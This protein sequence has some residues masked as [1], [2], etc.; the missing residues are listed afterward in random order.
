MPIYTAAQDEIKRKIRS[1]KK[2][3]IKIRF[4]HLA[5]AE[6]TR[7]LSGNSEKSKLVWD[8]FFNINH[9]QCAKKNCRYTLDQLAALSQN[10]F[11]NVVYE[12]FW[13]LYYRFYKENG[14]NNAQTFDPSILTKFGLP[15]NADNNTIKKKFRDL[16]K[17][18][19]PDTGGD[20]DEFIDFMENYKKLNTN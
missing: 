14:L 4:S 20:H 7:I 6:K 16:A 8:E 19:H 1:L 15:Y 13:H 2:L 9:Q 11:K 18:Y 3:E 5:A 12:Y 10:E 17:K